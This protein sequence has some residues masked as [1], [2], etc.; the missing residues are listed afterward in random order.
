MAG[1]RFRLSFLTFVLCAIPLSMSAVMAKPLHIDDTTPS[2]IP[3]FSWVPASDAGAGKFPEA[4][5]ELPGLIDFDA[6][7]RDVYLGQ[8]VLNRTVKPAFDW[9]FSDR[10]DSAFARRTALIDSKKI[11]GA[12]ESN[13]LRTQDASAEFQ[14]NLW[15]QHNFFQS[16]MSA[17]GQSASDQF[18]GPLLVI[19]F[20]T[21]AKSLTLFPGS[22]GFALAQD[23]RAINAKGQPPFANDT[24]APVPL[25]ASSWFLGTAVLS[26]LL[27]RRSIRRRYLQSK[28]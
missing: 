8:A 24:P 6:L 20:H 15:G 2:T 10:D 14:V 26:L 16:G 9:K 7:W 22:F 3:R 11:I 13:N 4:T 28:S 5:R 18:T 1:F 27:W 12:L 17:L 19:E 21:G 23:T 25:P